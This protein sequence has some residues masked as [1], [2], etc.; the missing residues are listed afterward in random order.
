MLIEAG[1]EGSM[2][3]VAWDGEPPKD[4]GEWIQILQEVF[5]GASGTYR[6]RFHPGPRGWRFDL[7]CRDDPTPAR[8]DVIANSPQT[9]RFT[10]VQALREKGKP[11]DPDWH[12][13]VDTP[14]G[15]LR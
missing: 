8:A 12:G 6:L 13:E 5:A 9:V 10:L 4:K 15:R 11:I 14:A 3:I 7:E 1:E 2:F